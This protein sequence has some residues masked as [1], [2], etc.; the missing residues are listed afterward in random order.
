MLLICN[1]S[2]SYFEYK[3]YTDQFVDWIVTASK[4]IN[5]KSS[6][7]PL[8]LSGLTKRVDVI[9]ENII[10]TPCLMEDSYHSHLPKILYIG[11][12][13]IGLRNQVSSIYDSIKSNPSLDSSNLKH[14]HFIE[15]LKEC[16]MKLSQWYN[17][18]V[19]NMPP[20][21]KDGVSDVTDGGVATHSNRF[22]ILSDDDLTILS[23]MIQN[24]LM[25]STSESNTINVSES[26]IKLD[27]DDIYGNLRVAVICFMLDLMQVVDRSP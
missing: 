7:L 13:A 2:G 22:H 25:I 18:V 19:S 27:D 24:D 20:S 11:S 23:D 17:S 9:V 15:I 21:M 16:H 12:K 3:N 5:K 8:T 1:M 26:D 6:S 4:A 14:V 10:A